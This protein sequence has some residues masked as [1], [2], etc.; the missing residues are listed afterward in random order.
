[1]TNLI[2]SALQTVSFLSVWIFSVL[3]VSPTRGHTWRG[4]SPSQA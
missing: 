3:R 1:M 2:L 4:L